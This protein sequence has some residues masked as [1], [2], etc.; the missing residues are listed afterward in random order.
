[1]PRRQVILYLVLF[2]VMVA[3]WALH[4]WWFLRKR[5][6]RRKMAEEGRLPPKAPRRKGTLRRSVHRVLVA[7]AVAAVRGGDEV[8]G[9]HD[10]RNMVAAAR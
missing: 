4:A 9:S 1:M 8:R 3:A 10:R 7:I 6:L 2:A 5:R